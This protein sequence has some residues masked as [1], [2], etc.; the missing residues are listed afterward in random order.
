MNTSFPDPGWK[1]CPSLNS[2]IQYVCYAT[3]QC[4][5][6]GCCTQFVYKQFK[7]WSFW[8]II[9]VVGAFLYCCWWFCKMLKESR[10]KRQRNNLSRNMFLSSNSVNGSP[11]TQSHIVS[12]FNSGEN[13]SST[14]LS[15]SGDAPPKY[16]DALNMPRRQD[17][18]TVEIHCDN[19]LTSVESNAE[20]T[21]S[22][23]EN[24]PTYE[25]AKKYQSEKV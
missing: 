16:R 13:A 8:L 5:L 3:E 19:Q 17:I 1:L 18:Q 15:K 11:R 25:D 14:K 10:Q 12:L 7:S 23:S 4:C 2:Q 9:I 21:A 22:T 20:A 24:L 6:T